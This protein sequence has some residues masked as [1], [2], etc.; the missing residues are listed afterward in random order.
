MDMDF[1]KAKKP[2]V[3]EPLSKEPKELPGFRGSSELPELG[4]D[5]IAEKDLESVSEKIDKTANL[6]QS[7]EVESAFDDDNEE[8]PLDPTDLTLDREKESSTTNEEKNEMQLKSKKKISKKKLILILVLV[9]ALLGAGGYYGYLKFFKKTAETQDNNATNSSENSQTP[10]AEKPKLVPAPITGVD[11]SEEA[12]AK[13][14]T[15]VMIE[16]STDARPQSGLKSAD[17][18]MEAVA[19]GGITRFVALFQ[20][21]NP[22]SIG[23]IRSA[24]PYYVELAKTFDAAYVHAGGSP[25]GL[26]R[27]ADLGVKDMS[28]FDNDGT[29]IRISSRAAPHNLYSSMANLDIKRAQLGYT[30]SSFTT[31]T[32]KSDTPQTPTANTIHF[33]MSGVYYNPDYTY[34]IATNSYRRSINGEPQ[35]DASPG[36][37]VDPQ[38]M[39]KV[40]ISLVTSK[41][42]SGQYSTY[43]LTGSGTMVVFQDGIVSEGTWTKD[44][45]SSQFIFKDKNGLDFSFNKGQIWMTLLGSRGDIAYQP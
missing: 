10:V 34:D 4:E 7:N 11:V 17:L 32:H 37:G 12:A 5:E 2:K 21:G 36:E 6:A 43:Q 1:R 14:V 18:V 22:E 20:Q 30:S 35:T 27:V 28:A 39:P 29:Y 13:P 25:D 42:Q 15:A 44:S 26:Q 33:N 40:L 9:L 16:N 8:I 19:E 38:I 31:W 23:P 3:V 24:R 45:A 41:G